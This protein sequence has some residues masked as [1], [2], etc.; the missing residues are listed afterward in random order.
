[1]GPPL[2]RS[3]ASSIFTVRNTRAFVL[4]WRH[5]SL[6]SLPKCFCRSV[7]LTP[8]SLRPEGLS[9][10]QSWCWESHSSLRQLSLVP[11]VEPELC[12]PP[13]GALWDLKFARLPGLPC[14]FPISAPITLAFMYR[15]T[16]LHRRTW[17]PSPTALCTSGPH[18]QPPASLRDG[19]GKRGSGL[20]S[21]IPTPT[22]TCIPKPWEEGG[23]GRRQVAPVPQAVWGCSHLLPL[24]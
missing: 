1:M 6:P 9:H 22:L 19:A 18:W 10:L 11:G 3:L 17:R 13:Q 12:T 21:R 5:P 8:L 2:G 14:P 16:A 7:S 15:Q 20:L 4:L 23:R 24:P